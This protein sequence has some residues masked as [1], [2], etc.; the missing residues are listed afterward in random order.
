[1]EYEYL[2]RKSAADFCKVSIRTIDR[3]IVDGRI[4]S[5]KP[6]GCSRVLIIKD[7]LSRENLSSPKPKY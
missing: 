7:S 2:S 6:D 5:F 4:D 3:W 1:M